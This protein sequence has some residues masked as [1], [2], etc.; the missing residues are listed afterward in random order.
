MG[1]RIIKTDELSIH[2]IPDPDADWDEI[3]DFALTF[4]PM[5][6]LGTTDIY[7]NGFLKFEENASLVELRTTL[8]LLQRGTNH[9]GHLP[10][11]ILIKVNQL[12]TFMRKKV[13]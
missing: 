3:S 5:L 7:K 11:D 13:S 12:I 9:V 10:Q 2:D 4:D 6:E 8:F 1:R